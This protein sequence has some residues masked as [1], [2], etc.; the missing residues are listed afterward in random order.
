MIYQLV[1]TS[2]EY[3]DYLYKPF[4]VDN[5]Q[6]GFEGIKNLLI[7]DLDKKMLIFIN[8]CEIKNKISCIYDKLSAS[9]NMKELKKI[10]IRNRAW[11]LM[12]KETKDDM[13]DCRCYHIILFK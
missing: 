1:L 11:E 10:V 3:W 12:M 9:Q 2:T 6:D 8:D 7:K 5:E 4:F 13:D